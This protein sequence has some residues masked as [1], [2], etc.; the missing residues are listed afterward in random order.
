MDEQIEVNS[1][2]LYRRQ[3]VQIRASFSRKLKIL[4]EEQHRSMTAQVELWIE[5]EWQRT[6]PEGD[7]NA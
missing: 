4:A 7:N 2:E 6:H 1:T 3:P 5:Q